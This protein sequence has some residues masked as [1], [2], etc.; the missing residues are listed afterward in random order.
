VATGYVR[1][2]CLPSCIVDHVLDG[3]QTPPSTAGSSLTNPQFFYGNS[4]SAQSWS[5]TAYS[6]SLRDQAHIQSIP[7][8]RFSFNL[9]QTKPGF[10]L[11]ISPEGPRTLTTTCGG[12]ERTRQITRLQRGRLS[13]RETDAGWAWSFLVIFISGASYSRGLYRSLL[14]NLCFCRMDSTLPRVL[15]SGSSF[16]HRCLA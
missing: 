12:T 11:F 6:R 5:P 3:Y 4:Y 9:H 15:F 13:D 7:I 8:L 1:R 2:P 10:Q 14:M 16:P